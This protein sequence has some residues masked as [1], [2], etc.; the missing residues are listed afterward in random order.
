VLEDAGQ[1]VPGLADE[2]LRQQAA[3]SVGEEQ[4]AQAGKRLGYVVVGRAG[5]DG[6]EAGEQP[7][8]RLLV[9]DFV[10]VLVK[11][12]ARVKPKKAFSQFFP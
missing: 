4:L 9:L 10:D 6:R 3:L 5:R 12:H 11:K 2:L 7:V 1:V 8:H